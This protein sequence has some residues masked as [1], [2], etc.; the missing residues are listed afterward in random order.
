[1]LPC[2]H[3]NAQLTKDRGGDSVIKM[4]VKLVDLA[5]PHFR[6]L[7]NEFPNYFNRALRSTGWWLRREVQEG[8]R[9]G[10]P[11]GRRYARYSG[12]T[13]SRVLDAHRGRGFTK[14]GK[15]R[16]PRRNLADHKPMGKLYQATRY[17]HYKDS[18]RVLIG[19]ISKS[20]EELGTVQERGKSIPITPKMRRFFWASGVPLS[21]RK[22]YL[23]IPKRLTIEPE[24]RENAPRVAGYIDRK[25]GDYLE[26]AK[27]R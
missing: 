5:T 18:N 25:I 16:A 12:V 4:D 22:R 1:M 23:Y 3:S 15:R 2:I 8:I 17:K 26:E 13:T 27:S 14:T 10:A 11:G 21:P 9:S 7:S 6:R 20:A 19:W 24:Y